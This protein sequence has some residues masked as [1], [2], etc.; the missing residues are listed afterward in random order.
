MIRIEQ[1]DDVCSLLSL[2]SAP[3]PSWAQPGVE[4][5][6]C[7]GV[8]YS[9][10][11]YTGTI[12]RGYTMHRGCVIHRGCDTQHDTKQRGVIHITQAHILRLLTCIFPQFST[13]FDWLL[14][15]SSLPS[16]WENLRV[17]K[18]SVYRG[19]ESV[20]GGTTCLVHVAALTSRLSLSSSS[21]C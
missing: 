21:S 8:I 14:K 7:E 6:R 16:S 18:Y 4:Q 19:D 17:G 11:P 20:W 15:G 1:A 13:R 3:Y 9:C 10:V 12:Y 5:E 2:I